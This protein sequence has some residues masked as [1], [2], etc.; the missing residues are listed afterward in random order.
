MILTTHLHLAPRLLSRAVSVLTSVCFSDLLR[1]DLY[2][3]I[4]SNVCLR[5]HMHL[6][7]QRT[8]EITLCMSIVWVFK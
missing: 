4:H 2:L 1:R 7:D 3:R 5:M 8:G 6:G